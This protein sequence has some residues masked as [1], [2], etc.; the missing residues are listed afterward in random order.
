MGTGAKKYL[1]DRFIRIWYTKGGNLEY[2]ENE[3]RYSPMPGF[4]YAWFYNGV[5]DKMLEKMKLIN[6]E[7][8]AI[9]NEDGKN[10]KIVKP[11]KSLRNRLVVWLTKFYLV[12]FMFD[13]KKYYKDIKK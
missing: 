10:N 3:G 11:V 8:S 13:N 4:L 7:V 12:H 2:L 6:I 1:A 9:G 5:T